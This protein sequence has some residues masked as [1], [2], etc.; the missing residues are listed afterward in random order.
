MSA[1]SADVCS[2]CPYGAIAL[3]DFT[4]E[5]H[6][7]CS[8]ASRRKYTAPLI[9]ESLRRSPAHAPAGFTTRVGRLQVPG[10]LSFTRCTVM[11]IVR[12]SST[13]R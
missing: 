13:A 8:L 2:G 11:L 9:T 5:V 10:E 3:A 7:F 6:A 4:A 12:H 1:S